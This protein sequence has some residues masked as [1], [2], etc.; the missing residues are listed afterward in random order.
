M[1]KDEILKIAQEYDL[2][3]NNAQHGISLMGIVNFGLLIANY[4]REQCAKRLDAVGCDHCATNI[5]ARGQE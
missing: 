1:T 3:A 4:E 5:R 2:I